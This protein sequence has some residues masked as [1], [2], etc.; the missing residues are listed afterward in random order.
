MFLNLETLATITIAE[1]VHANYFKIAFPNK[2][3]VLKIGTNS[4]PT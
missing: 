2:A 3:I 4:H 1:S